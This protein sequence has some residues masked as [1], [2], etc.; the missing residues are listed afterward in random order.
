[1]QLEKAGCCQTSITDV[2]LGE[3]TCFGLRSLGAHPLSCTANCSKMGT[4]FFL[5]TADT[6]RAL[7]LCKINEAMLSLVNFPSSLPALAAL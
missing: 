6:Q 3:T 5:H 7:F 1:M 2:L 4:D